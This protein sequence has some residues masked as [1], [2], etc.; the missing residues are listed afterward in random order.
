MGPLAM[1]FATHRM[2]LKQPTYRQASR[3]T[4]ELLERC[5]QTVKIP[6]KFCV[7]VGVAGAIVMYDRI[8]SL[9]GYPGRALSSFSAPPEKPAHVFGGPVLRHLSK[10][11]AGK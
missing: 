4:P 7:N 11:G 1:C 5:D 9:G 3:V 8:R 10:K 2:S 6:T